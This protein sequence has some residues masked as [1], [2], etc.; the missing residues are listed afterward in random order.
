M[1]SSVFFAGRLWRTPVTVSQ[2]DDTAEAPTSLTVG[3]VLAILGIAQG[4]QPNA[5][6]TFDNPS[7]VAPVLKGGELCTAVTK[8][9]NPSNDDGVNAPGTVIAIRVGTS[10]PAALTLN[11]SASAAAINLATT[12]YGVQ[13]NLTKVKVETGTVSGKKLTVQLGQSFYTG[14]NIG[15]NAFNV[16]YTG[17]QSTATMTVSNSTVTL[18]A[19]SGTPVATIDLNVY[20]NVLQLVDRINATPSFTATV[21]A[22]SETTPALNGLDSVTAHDVKTAVYTETANLQACVDWFNSTA[23][24][25]VTAVRP[26]GA[27]LAPANIAF[28]YLA[29]GTDPAVL[30]QDWTNALTVL[31][32]ADVQWVVPLSSDPAIHAAVDA[33]VQFMSGQGR[34]ERRAL[35]GPAIGTSLAAV[36]AL[37]L[38]LDSDRTSI[39]WP[40]YY[41]YDVNGVLTLYAPYFTAVLVA[42]GFAGSNP[43]TPMTN[44]TLTVRGLELNPNNPADT[45]LLIESGVLCL[46]KTPQGYKVVRSISAWLSNDNYNRVEVSC[47]AATDFTVRNVR[48]ALDHLRGSRGDPNILTR[49][50]TTTETALKQLAKAPPEGPGVIVGDANN[51]AFRN[52]TASLTGDVLTVDYEC[53]P[54]IPVN[55][56]L[57][58]VAIVPFSGTASA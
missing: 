9:F 13:T 55:F 47:G 18:S 31:Q 8:A 27:G 5:V 2:V 58:S 17:G 10:T 36:Q 6:L 51:P 32:G 20:K 49:A 28:T 21:A 46:E 45:D 56:I 30:T 42:A 11:D 12:D 3:N 39:C 1:A 22:G 50:I 37:P 7:Q 40:G 24:G 33:H 44:K 16:Q 43:G 26:A 23:Q 35:C 4:G 34:K 14:D 29:G 25:Y 53:S 19:P 41:D 52:I 54:V 57:N 48:D 15:R 38:A